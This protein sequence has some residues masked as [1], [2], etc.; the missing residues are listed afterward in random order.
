MVD[1]RLLTIREWVIQPSVNALAPMNHNR[2]RRDIASPF[3][4]AKTAEGSGV[5][6]AWS[7]EWAGS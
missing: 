5:G 1:I 7:S 4:S 3:P 2:I 6:S